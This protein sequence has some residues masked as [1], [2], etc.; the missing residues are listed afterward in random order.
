MTGAAA[1]LEG[2]RRPGFRV[3][4]AHP[5]DRSALVAAGI[6]ALL[7]LLIWSPNIGGFDPGDPAA[8]AGDTRLARCGGTV[9]DVEFAFAIPRA[10]DYQTYLPAMPD[11]S[12]LE[13]D[14]P[15]LI[16]IYRGAFPGVGTSAILAPPPRNSTD[17]NVC[18]Y[19]GPA[20]QGARNYYSRIA[21]DGLRNG[22]NGPIL[23]PG[24][25]T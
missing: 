5:E 19:V 1:R 16:V 25:Q 9:A 18:V 13:S 2:V 4:P 21:I 23:V 15:A 10:R 6:A 11:S 20:G 24:P 14:R 12:S 17:R 7:A 22:P 3:V 8:V